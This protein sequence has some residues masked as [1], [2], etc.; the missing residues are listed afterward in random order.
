M[1]SDQGSYSKLSVF[2]CSRGLFLSF[3]DTMFQQCTE[4]SLQMALVG[5]TVYFSCKAQ[6]WASSGADFIIF[7]KKKKKGR[8][9]S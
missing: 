7:K 8:Q 9:S 5:I 1:L 2:E 3:S 4:S 6:A